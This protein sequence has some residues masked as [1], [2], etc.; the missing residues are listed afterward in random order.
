MVGQGLGNREEA[1]KRPLPLRTG[2]G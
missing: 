1:G 2:V